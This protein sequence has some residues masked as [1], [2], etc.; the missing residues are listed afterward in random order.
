MVQDTPIVEQPKQLDQMIILPIT[1]IIT[2]R[3]TNIRMYQLL[4]RQL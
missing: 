2:I 4:H 1:N 3:D